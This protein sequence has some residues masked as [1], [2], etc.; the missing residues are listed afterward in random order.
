MAHF[1]FRP[2]YATTIETLVQQLNTELQAFYQAISETN[3]LDLRT[4]HKEP[5]RPRDG[6]IVYADGT[7]WNPG[8]G[9]G[10]YVYDGGWV[11][12]V[13]ASELGGNTWDTI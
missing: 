9:R 3:T 4:T 7:D 8:S 6:L 11:R 2:I 10:L 12:L 13:K 5:S 1:E